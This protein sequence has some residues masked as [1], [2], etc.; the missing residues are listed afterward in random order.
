MIF[1]EIVILQDEDGTQMEFEL[2][3]RIQYAEQQYAVLGARGEDEGALVI[4]L[5][6]QESGSG[7]WIYDD[8]EDDQT[9][10]AVYDL[11]YQRHRD[12]FDFSD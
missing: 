7:Q 10:D 9:L 2:L 12:E 6:R 5:T 11:F 1:R 4:L 3:D 8:V